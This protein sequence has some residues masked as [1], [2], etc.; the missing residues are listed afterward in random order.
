M[1]NLATLID[2]ISI[3]LHV[4]AA[5]CKS[6]AADKN[7]FSKDSTFFHSCCLWGPFKEFF[8]VARNKN[9]FKKHY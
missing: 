9:I 2:N 3:I 6:S 7:F 4:C 8:R 1:K 5:L